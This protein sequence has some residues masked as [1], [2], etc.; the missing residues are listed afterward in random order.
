MLISQNVLLVIMY[1][2]YLCLFFQLHR[3]IL[4]QSHSPPIYNIISYFFKLRQTPVDEVKGLS[5][6]T[7]HDP[8]IHSIFLKEKVD[9]CTRNFFP[10]V[11]SCFAARASYLFRELTYTCYEKYRYGVRPNLHT[12]VHVVSEAPGVA[13]FKKS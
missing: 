11:K 2:K 1:Q 3:F 12:F 8:T 7:I 6:F 9:K 10:A 4:G 5:W 13:F